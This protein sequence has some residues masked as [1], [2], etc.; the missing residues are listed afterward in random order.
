[1]PGH[2]EHCRH[3]LEIYGFRAED[4]HTWMDA[5][6]QIYGSSHRWTRHDLALIPRK[7]INEYGEELTRQIMLDHI[8][9][10]RE[11]EPRISLTATEGKILPTIDLRPRSTSSSIRIALASLLIWAV[12]LAFL[13]RTGFPDPWLRGW[14][15]ASLIWFPVGLP[16]YCKASAHQEQL[17]TAEKVLEEHR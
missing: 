7:F 2:E 9:L 4:I 6:S 1:M 14:I 16:L 3:S 10:D 5:P 12:S 15:M 11:S 17:K 8:L 13:F